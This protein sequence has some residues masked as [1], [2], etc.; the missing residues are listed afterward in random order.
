GLD[1]IRATEAAAFKSGRW[2]GLGEPAE[3]DRVAACAM[4]D[5]LATIEMDGRIAIGE[6]ESLAQNGTLCSEEAV[7]TGRGAQVDVVVDPID[8]SRLLA[9]GHPGAI[10]VVAVSPRGTMWAPRAPAL[11]MEKIVV[12]ADVANALVPECMDAPAA[13]TLALVARV[14][15]K[16][17]SDLV[18]FVLDRPRHADLIEEI[19]RAGA[20]AMLRPDGDI[21]GALMASSP[22]SGVDILMGVGRIPEGLL[23]A[24][25]VKATGG[26]MLGRLAPQSTEERDAVRAAGLDDREV[27]TCDQLVSSN[28]IFFAATG[29]PDGPLLSGV[30]YIGDRCRSNSMILRGETRTRRLIYAE[31]LLEE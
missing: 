1:L 23:A 24:C 9:Q 31:H 16:R 22:D 7:G 3:A 21:A 17:V 14:K 27:L 11:Y 19:R 13:W 26:A 28:M 10:S 29:I 2:M 4:H 15:H 8:G 6:E 25:A 5:A 20:R 18:V 12:G 30:H